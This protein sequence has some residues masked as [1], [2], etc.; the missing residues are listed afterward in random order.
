MESLISNI[1]NDIK[2]RKGTMINGTFVKEC[3]I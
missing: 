3:D 2:D 1:A